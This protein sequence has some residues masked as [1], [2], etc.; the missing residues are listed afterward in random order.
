[1][2]SLQVVTREQAKAQLRVSSNSEDAKID[3]LIGSATRN[4]ANVLN[5]ESVD[6]IPGL[7]DSP[8]AVPE[9]IQEAALLYITA[10]YENPSAQIDQ[11]IK[12]N[13]RYLDLLYFYRQRLGI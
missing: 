1:M 11:T 5:L 6:D 12:D 7:T 9:D 2:A 8:Q 10:G 13:P 4:I 3:L